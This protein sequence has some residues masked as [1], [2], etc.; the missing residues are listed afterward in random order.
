M[1]KSDFVWIE[2]CEHY[3]KSTCRNRAEILTSQGIQVLSIPLKQGRSN[4]KKNIREV[5]ID[6][7]T[8]WQTA[9]WRSI[10]SAYGRSPYFMY[11]EESIKQMIF[12]EEEYLF[13]FNLNVLRSLFRLLKMNVELHFTE[14]Y[15][16]HY[17]QD[18]V[19][20]RTAKK[21]D[22]NVIIQYSQCFEDKNGFIPNVSIIDM[23]MNCGTDAVSILNK[24]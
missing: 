11:Y 23:L 7:T 16:A 17:A 9:H 21:E 5:L 12:H 19:D 22:K 18:F 15:I 14:T 1:L 13:E 6:N 10:C 24:K 3:V 20:L 4:T 8:A 2:Q